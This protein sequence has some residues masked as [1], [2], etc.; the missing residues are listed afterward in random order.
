MENATV[1][2]AASNPNRMIRSRPY[3]R[4]YRSDRVDFEPVL[5]FG[6]NFL[7]WLNRPFVTLL[8]HDPI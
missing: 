8:S 2:N 3:A 6:L 1:G 4:A 7:A 5:R